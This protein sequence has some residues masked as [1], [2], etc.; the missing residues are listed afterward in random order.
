M[1]YLIFATLVLAACER[2]DAGRDVSTADTMMDTL[3]PARD[4]ARS[5][6]MSA[7]SDRLLGSWTAKG[8]DAGSTRAQTFTINWTRAPDGSLGGTIAFQG[9]TQYKVKVV[10]TG[11]STFVYES[12]PHQSPTLK[13]QVVTRTQARLVGDTL[14]GSYEAK[15][16]TGKSLKGSF[17]ATRG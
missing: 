3:G 7:V 14:I 9:G 8:Y 6:T 15:P 16:K 11:D 4:T 1:R 12:E 17:K 2:R 5:Q 13:A 10:S